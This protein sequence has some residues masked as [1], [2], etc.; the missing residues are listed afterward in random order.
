MFKIGYEKTRKGYVRL[1]HGLQASTQEVE[2]SS[3]GQVILYEKK[4]VL[5]KKMCYE[6]LFTKN[7]LLVNDIEDHG[8]ISKMLLK[9]RNKMI[10]INIL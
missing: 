1:A 5:Y 7:E 6:F 10:H 4:G 3:P 2:G 9:H 8:T